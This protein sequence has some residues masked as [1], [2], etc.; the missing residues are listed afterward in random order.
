MVLFA[1]KA[2][3][4][5]PTVNQCEISGRKAQTNSEGRSR[6]AEVRGKKAESGN[7]TAFEQEQT[8]ET[9]AQGGEKDDHVRI[10]LAV[11]RSWNVSGALH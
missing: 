10:L 4:D 5:L 6:R 8:E 2:W 11:E 1:F 7:L 9:D 3:A